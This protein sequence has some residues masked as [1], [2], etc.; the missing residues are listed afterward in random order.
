MKIVKRLCVFLC[1]FML[2]GCCSNGHKESEPDVVSSF[3]M[4]LD[5]HLIVVANRKKIENT[6]DFA[7]GLVEKCRKNSFKSTIFSTDYGYPT[8]LKMDVYLWKEDIGNSDPIMKIEY[9]PKKYAT[10]VNIK[11][12]PEKFDLFIDNEIQ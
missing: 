12:D 4:N 8:S 1:F 6:K 9:L 10:D 2:S 11:N 3:S 5:E 7:E